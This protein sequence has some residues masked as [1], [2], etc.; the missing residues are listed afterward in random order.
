MNIR[1]K[2]NI[3]L[4]TIFVI[5]ALALPALSTAQKETRPKDWAQPIEKKGL[6][7]FYKVSDDLYRGAQPTKE[8]MAELKKMGIKTIINLRSFNSD[9]DEMD[10]AGF[11]YVHIFMKAWHPEYHETVLFLKTI[12][13]KNNLPAFVHCMHGADRTGTMCAIYRMA[14]LSWP[15]DK[16]MEEML[17][18]GFGYHPVWDKYLLPFLRKLDVEKLKKDAGI[19]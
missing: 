3:L 2:N 1:I 14:I 5:A 18:G 13:D 12:S 10:G 17:K 11:K 16:A 7:N 15:R 6:P 19:K 9:K 8:G 4:L